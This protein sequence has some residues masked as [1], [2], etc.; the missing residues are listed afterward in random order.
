MK[1]MRFFAITALALAAAPSLGCATS[2]GS[3]T[4]AERVVIAA[5]PTLASSEVVVTETVA[6]PAAEQPGRRR[7]SRTVTLGQGASEPLYATPVAQQGTGDGPNVTVNNNVT[8]VNQPPVIYG[9]YGYGYGYGS[10]YGAGYGARD[11]GRGAGA[12]SSRPAWAPSGWE[13]AQRTAAPG[14][15]PGV[16]GNYAPAPSFGPAPMR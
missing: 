4:T 8:V 14:R 5:P 15:T 6:A 13:G 2:M 3:A 1:G 12:T 11:S 7:L 10:S 9:G 16:G